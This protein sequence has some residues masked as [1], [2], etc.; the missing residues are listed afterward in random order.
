MTRYSFPLLIFFTTSFHDSRPHPKLLAAL[1]CNPRSS[2]EEPIPEIPARFRPSPAAR[3]RDS[4][5]ED[6]SISVSRGSTLSLWSIDLSVKS[7]HAAVA[8]GHE[9]TSKSAYLTPLSEEVQTALESRRQTVDRTRK[10]LGQ[11]PGRCGPG[12]EDRFSRESGRTD[13]DDIFTAASADAAVANTLG[14]SRGP[15]DRAHGPSR[16]RVFRSVPGMESGPPHQGT[17][18]RSCRSVPLPPLPTVDEAHVYNEIKDP[19]SPANTPRNTA[20]RNGGDR[21]RRKPQS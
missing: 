10:E 7:Q 4:A 16:G 5:L 1:H 18:L 6:E 20:H 11:A 21:Q 14:L 9:Q 17:Q 13:S 8:S 15:M 12:A 19:P 3:F 2:A